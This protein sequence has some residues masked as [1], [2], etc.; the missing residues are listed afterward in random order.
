[1]TFDFTS[2]GWG[3]GLVIC[4]WVAGMVV[5]FVFKIIRGVAYF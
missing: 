4:G 5:G 3:L 2:F 1:M